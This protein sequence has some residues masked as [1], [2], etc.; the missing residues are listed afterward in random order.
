MAFGGTE[1]PVWV[2]GGRFAFFPEKE[3]PGTGPEA[4]KPGVKFWTQKEKSG[5]ENH[6]KS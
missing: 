1:A 4:A 5:D 2:N 3:A 6:P